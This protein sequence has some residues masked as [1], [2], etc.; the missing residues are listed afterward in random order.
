MFSGAVVKESVMGIKVFN[1][2][3]KILIHIL[4][5]AAFFKLYFIPL[6]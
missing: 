2:L 6:I 1:Y 3:F 5:T 4:K